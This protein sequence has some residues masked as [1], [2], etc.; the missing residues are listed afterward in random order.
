MGTRVIMQGFDM[1]DTVSFLARLN[2]KNQAILLARIEEVLDHNT[3]EF[4]AVRKIVLD[5]TNDYTRS[6]VKKLFGNTE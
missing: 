6:I 5:S 2:K 1:M 3:P 4:I